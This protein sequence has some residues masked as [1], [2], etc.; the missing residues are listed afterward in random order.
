MKRLLVAAV[1]LLASC[2]GKSP[3]QTALETI[4]GAA[5]A[6]YDVL[7]AAGKAHKTG[8]ITDAQL[9]TIVKDGDVLRGALDA[10]VATTSAYAATKG[11]SGSLDVS[12]V[13]TDLV[14]LTRDWEAL[15]GSHQP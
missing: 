12:A 1:L 15:N 2:A 7:F 4:R 13:A 5:A 9:K 6:R 11:A 8:A 14:L 10:A 3:E